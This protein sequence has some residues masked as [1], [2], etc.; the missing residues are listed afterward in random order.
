MLVFQIMI[1]Y[2]YR[3]GKRFRG[4]TSKSA[5][6]IMHIA[7]TPEVQGFLSRGALL[8]VGVSGGKDSQAAALAVAANRESLGHKGPFILIHADLGKVEWDQ[9]LLVCQRLA[10]RIGAE[11]VTVQRHAGGLMERWE[12]RWE[13]SVR[14]YSDLTTMKIVLPWSTSSMRFC[15]SE[16]KVAP[17]NSELRRRAQAAG[18]AEVVSACG[19]RRDESPARRLKPVASFAPRGS[20]QSVAL[21]NWNPIIDWTIGQVIDSIER[22]GLKLH[23]A[24]TAH[25]LTRVSCR[26]CVLASGSDLRAA[27]RAEENADLFR[28]MVELETRSTFGFQGTNGWLADVA[29][30]LLTPAEAA[31]VASAKERARLRTEAEAE[32]P[33]DLLHDKGGWPKRMPSPAEADLIASVRGRVA[34]AVGLGEIGFRNGRAVFDRFAELLSRPRKG[35]PLRPPGQGEEQLGLEM[36]LF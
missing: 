14:R 28:R 26:F 20:T 23:E 25:G 5:Q 7:L 9:S 15:T 11:L 32:I 3:K 4:L 8:A 12:S 34:A 36:D 21:W 10:E 30:T 27:A 17:I 22:S 2:H 29:P 13:S 18:I 16:L 6:S 1:V 19:I 33:N 24:Y 31:A 35:Q